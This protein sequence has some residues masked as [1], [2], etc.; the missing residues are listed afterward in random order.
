MAV[1]FGCHLKFSGL[2]VTPLASTIRSWILAAS[3]SDSIRLMLVPF[4]A[5]WY[6]GFLPLGA[7]RPTPKYV[8]LVSG[9]FT[10]TYAVRPNAHIGRAPVAESR[11]RMRL[12][13]DL[14]SVY[15][16]EHNHFEPAV[17]S[18][19]GVLRSEECV[20]CCHALSY[21]CICP[22]EPRVRNSLH[23]LRAKSFVSADDLHAG[24]TSATTAS[25]NAISVASLASL[26]VCA[27]VLDG[28]D[29]LPSIV[30]HE[31]VRA[32]DF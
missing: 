25:F 6:S 18:V 27:F 24:G 3:I 11:T 32:V 29:R 8:E 19:R 15:G 20:I 22:V 12:G 31:L 7:R 17:V 28:M 30:Q 5:T 14:L 9:S 10:R 23:S 13:S 16:F 2:S 1:D 26:G 21:P 4:E